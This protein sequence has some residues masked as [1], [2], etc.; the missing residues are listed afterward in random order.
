MLLFL[1]QNRRIFVLSIHALL[2]NTATQKTDSLFADCTVKIL[3]RLSQLQVVMRRWT[4]VLS[5]A[6]KVSGL[7]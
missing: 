5:Q 2:R 3:K 4:Q 1:K 7:L 6:L